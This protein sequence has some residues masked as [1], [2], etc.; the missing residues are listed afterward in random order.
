MFW[1]SG[2]DVYWLS[3]IAPALRALGGGTATTVTNVSVAG[4]I[5]MTARVAAIRMANTATNAYFTTGTPD[6]SF[7]SGTGLTSVNPTGDIHMKHPV[8]SGLKI[9]RATCRERVCQYV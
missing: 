2:T 9:G 1:Q 4:M 8:S 6:F 3:A 7:A 5:P